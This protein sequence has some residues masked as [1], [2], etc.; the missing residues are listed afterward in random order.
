MR[1]LGV[2][3]VS[4]WHLWWRIATVPANNATDLAGIPVSICTPFLVYECHPQL[5]PISRV[6]SVS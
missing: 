4:E 6:G 2:I 3:Q 5:Y 1:L